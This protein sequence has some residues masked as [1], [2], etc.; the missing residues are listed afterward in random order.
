M[1]IKDVLNR[2][3]KL[4]LKEG[5]KAKLSTIRMARS[6][7]LYA[8]KA[9]LRELDEDEVIEVLFREVKTRKNDA[10]EYERLGKMDVAEDLQREIEVLQSYLPQMLT[11]DEVEE[12]VRQ[13]IVE[14]GANSVKDLGKVMGAVMPKVKGRADGGIVNTLA[15]KLL[16]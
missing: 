2:D 13:S 14:V 11:A 7:I 6:A 15:K 10:A 1:S 16:Q 9:K 3:M 4:A 12:I 8:E 5:R